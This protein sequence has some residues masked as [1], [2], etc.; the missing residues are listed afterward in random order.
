MY[1]RVHEIH[2]FHQMNTE[3]PDKISGACIVCGQAASL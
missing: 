3:L 1:A 2:R